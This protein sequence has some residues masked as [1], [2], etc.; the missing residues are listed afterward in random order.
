M[1]FILQ[2]G[3]TTD[4]IDELVHNLTIEAEAYPSPL[5][6]SGFPKSVCT[7]VNNVCV[8]GIPDLRPLQDGDIVNV[9]MTVSSL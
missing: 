1:Y 4:D 9:D 8:H 5:H 6:Y 7:S 2:P 3:V